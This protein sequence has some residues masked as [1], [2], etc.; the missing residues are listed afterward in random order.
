MFFLLRFVVSLFWPVQGCGAVSA[1][2]GR[3]CAEAYDCERV[4]GGGRWLRVRGGLRRERRE[5]ASP[6]CVCQT[7]AEVSCKVM[8]AAIV[9]EEQRRT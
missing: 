9:K 7:R 1:G 8:G 2:D 3:E 6:L 4:R 5:A